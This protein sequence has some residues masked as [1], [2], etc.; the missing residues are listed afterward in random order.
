MTFTEEISP[1]ENDHLFS[2]KEISSVISYLDTTFV[3]ESE[4]EITFF[5]TCKNDES[6]T[7]N[8]HNQYNIYA[9]LW[10]IPKPSEIISSN[11]QKIIL[12]FWQPTIEE[13]TSAALKRQQKPTFTI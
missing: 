1:I 12:D 8:V 7:L 11:G 2:D 4:E 5:H 3:P 6:R 9:H 13:Q 10:T